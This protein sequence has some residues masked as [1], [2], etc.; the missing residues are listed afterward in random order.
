MNSDHY[1][2]T[3]DN[4]MFVISSYPISQALQQDSA[5]MAQYSV[6]VRQYPIKSIDW[7]VE[8]GE[9]IPMGS[10]ID[11][12]SIMKLPTDAITLTLTRDEGDVDI[13]TQTFSQTEVVS[14]EINTFDFNPGKYYLSIEAQKEVI[15]LNINISGLR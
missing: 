1:W 13:F 8:E 7:G 5:T 10:I 3:S 15:S 12:T 4:Y 9:T 11:V 6:I 14:A 2:N